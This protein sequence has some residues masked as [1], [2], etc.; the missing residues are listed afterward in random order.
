MAFQV[1]S[2]VL[3]KDKVPTWFNDEMAKG[4]AKAN[5][6][7][8]ELTSVSVFVPTKTLIANIGDTIMML[9]SGLTVIPAEKAKKFGMQ[10]KEQKNE[11]QDD[12]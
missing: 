4:R 6:T 7:D 5:Y 12:K 11:K 10:P 8:D 9:K 2:F 1:K 3:G